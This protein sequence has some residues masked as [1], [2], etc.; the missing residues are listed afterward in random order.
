MSHKSLWLIETI[1]TA[2]VLMV[3]A[4]VLAPRMG[5]A[6]TDDTQTTATTTDQ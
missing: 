5:L 2:I 6:Q 1:I 4:Q 3:M